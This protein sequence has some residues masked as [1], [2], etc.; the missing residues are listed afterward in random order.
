MT[1]VTPAAHTHSPLTD[2]KTGTVKQPVKCGK[3]T[4]SFFDKIYCISID[5]RRDRRQQARKQFAAVGLLERVE[6][7]IVVRHPENRELG[8]FESH[9]TCLSRGLSAGA[10]NILVFEDDIC[11]KGHDHRLLVEAYLALA[12]IPNWNG[13]FLGAIT[14]GSRKTGSRFLVKVKYRCLS[15]AYALNRSFAQQI[16]REEWSGLPYDGLL[17]RL[18]ND[19]YAVCPMCAFQGDLSSDN[20]TPAI[21]RLRR[22][23]GG[24]YFIQK[25]NE[26]YQNHK[27]LLISVHLLFLSLFAVLLLRLW[28]Y[29]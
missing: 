18:C 25:A 6:F 9:L 8:I 17:R 13:L 15:H 10:G 4:W 1:G 5:D 20:Q 11:F 16:V 29:E 19:Y 27:P 2:N 12:R 14:E 22:L 21:D 28:Y 23:F 3:D 24:L 7:V 26:L